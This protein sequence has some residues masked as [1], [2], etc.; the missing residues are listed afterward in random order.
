MRTQ[1]KEGEPLGKTFWKLNTDVPWKREKQILG[2]YLTGSISSTCSSWVRDAIQLVVNI[3]S[4]TPSNKSQNLTCGGNGTIVG[5]LLRRGTGEG[6]ILV[7]LES[8]IL[9]SVLFLFLYE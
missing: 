8:N 9:N 5:D 4:I 7:Q 6:R 1:A 2:T 3:L